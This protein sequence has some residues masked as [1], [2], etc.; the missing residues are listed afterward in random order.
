MSYL[1]PKIR[2]MNSVSGS[3]AGNLP[4]AEKA[5]WSELEDNGPPAGDITSAN[6]TDATTVGVDVLTAT[7]AAAA[8]TAIGAGTSSLVLGTTATTALAGD[9]VIPT[10]PATLPP[11]D[12]SVTNAKVAASAAIAL[13]KLANVAAGTDGLAAGTIQA[14]LQ[15][16]ATRIQALEDAAAEV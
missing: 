3:S 14:T 12:A 4:D 1:E 2:Y 16:L 8:R 15:A 7:D 6:I 9:T 11:T 10:I 5:Y 13:S